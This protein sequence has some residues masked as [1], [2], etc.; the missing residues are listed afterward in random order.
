MKIIKIMEY[1]KNWILN[2]VQL[3]L[4]HLNKILFYIVV[5]KAKLIKTK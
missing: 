5:D 3:I 1:Y 2:K 4:I